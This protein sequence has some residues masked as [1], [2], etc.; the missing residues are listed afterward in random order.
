M[1][2]LQDL[3]KIQ[4]P[5]VQDSFKL[6]LLGFDHKTAVLTIPSKEH[7][8]KEFTNANV[9]NNHSEFDVNESDVARVSTL[10]HQPNIH[11][12]TNEDN[13]PI[14]EFPHIHDHNYSTFR[15]PV[16]VVKT[17]DIVYMENEIFSTNLQQVPIHNSK[18][19]SPGKSLLKEDEPKKVDDYI[20]LLP[21]YNLEIMEK[22]D[23]YDELAILFKYY[24]TVDEKLGAWKMKFSDCLKQCAQENSE[25]NLPIHNAVLNNNLLEVIK[26]C[27]ALRWKDLTVDIC[28]QQGRASPMTV[29]IDGNTALH[30]SV[31]HSKQISWVNFISTAEL[32]FNLVNRHGETPLLLS[33]TLGKYSEALMV[34]C[35]GGNP[36]VQDAWTGSTPL[37]RAIEN[38]DYPMVEILLQNNAAANISNYFGYSALDILNEVNIESKNIKKVVLQKVERDNRIEQHGRSENPTPPM[39]HEM[40]DDMDLQIYPPSIIDASAELTG[41]S[42]KSTCSLPGPSGIGAIS[43]PSTLPDSP[44]D[45]NN[46]PITVSRN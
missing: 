4:G 23:Y 24:G 46:P 6:D 28:N 42:M 41:L 5:T 11:S 45:Q 39:L 15:E 10:E 25:G 14:K 33:V 20:E 2:R 17:E 22:K 13:S 40:R 35:M 31:L 32:D 30:L 9:I 44:G 34:L 16:T 1:S 21:K 38:N 37:F 19:S 26:Q 36:N 7:L 29:D 27:L 3:F 18:P 8:F 12:A 43:K